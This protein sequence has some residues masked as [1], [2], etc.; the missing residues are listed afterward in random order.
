MPLV[1]AVRGPGGETLSQ[2]RR[3]SDGSVYRE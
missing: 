3:D 1:V 2:L